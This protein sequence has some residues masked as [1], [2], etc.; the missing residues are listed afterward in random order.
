MKNSSQ[1]QNIENF[2]S[3][4]PRNIVRHAP[5]SGDAPLHS[6]AVTGYWRLHG[7][8]HGP[9]FAAPTRCTN[10]THA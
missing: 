10:K 6:I 4:A 1:N 3:S 5:S 9:P 7:A 2:C 8:A